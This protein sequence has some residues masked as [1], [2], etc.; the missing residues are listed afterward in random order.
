MAKN[1]TLKNQLVSTVIGFGA[2]PDP[3]NETAEEDQQV[4]EFLNKIKNLRIRPSLSGI[5]KIRE[6]ARGQ[7]STPHS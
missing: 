6:Y 2:S 1:I 4:R 3:F 7:H 5:R